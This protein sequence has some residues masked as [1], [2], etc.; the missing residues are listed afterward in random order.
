MLL[1]VGIDIYGVI[2]IRPWCTWPDR[3]EEIDWEFGVSLDNLYVGPDY[4]AFGCLFG[5]MNYAGFRPIAAERGLPADA[6]AHT[7]AQYDGAHPTWM[8]WA[9]VEQ[10][11]WTEPAEHADARLHR[12]LRDADGRWTFHSKASWSREAYEV[13]GVPAPPP[14]TDPAIWPDGSVWTRGDV[15]YRAERLTRRDAV[16]E[17]GGWQPVWEVMAILAR[18]H[19]RENCRL[20]VWFD[21]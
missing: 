6:S 8:S 5:V 19:G 15:Q 4:D 11:D 3:P 20:V 13:L 10:I 16:S 1:G 14:G 12:Y 18:L 9:E 2:E 21:R 7:R 17:N